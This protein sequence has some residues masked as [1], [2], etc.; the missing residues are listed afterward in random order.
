VW[1]AKGEIG[2]DSG[3]PRL[4]MRP[5]PHEDQWGGERPRMMLVRR[6]TARTS[7]KLASICGLRCPKVYDTPITYQIYNQYNQLP[8]SPP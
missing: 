1:E 3:I 7:E 6:G 5:S 2:K 8:S 4:S